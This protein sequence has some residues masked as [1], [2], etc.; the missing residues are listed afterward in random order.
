VALVGAAV[1]PCPDTIKEA[2]KS[3]EAGQR[4]T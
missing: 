4:A 2:G 1:L 3:D